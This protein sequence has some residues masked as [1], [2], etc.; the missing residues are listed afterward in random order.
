L[1][2][3][4]ETNNLNL[5]NPKRKPAKRLDK[6]PANIWE[7]VLGRIETKVSPHSYRTWFRPT[8]F[9]AEDASSISVQV[10]NTWFAEWLETNYSVLIQETL[11]EM[12]HQG[13]VIDFKPLSES[14]TDPRPSAATA[15]RP[16]NRAT[17]NPKYTFETFVVSSCNQFAHAAA[18]A[19]AEQPTRAYNPLYIYGGVGLGK[20]HL[21]Q[22]IGNHIVALGN[23]R[24]HYISSEFFMNEL[25]NAIRFEKTLEFKERYRNVD[26]LLIDDIQ[27]LA[28]K[29]RT[30][31]EFFHTFN[32]LYDSQK[33]IVITSDV[34]PRDIPTLEERLR[35]RFEWGL[36]ADMQ[37]PDLETKVA[38]LQKK[39]ES[40]RS[41]VPDEVSLF[42]A[43]NC[44]TNVRELEGAFNKVVAYSSMSG[45]EINLDMAKKMLHDFMACASPSAT[46]DSIMKLVSNYYNLPVRELKSKNNSRQVAFPRHVAMYLSKKLTNCSFPEIGRR[47]GGKHH[48]TV[49]HAVQK[50]EKK[51][52]LEDDFH[53]LLESFVRSLK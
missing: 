16:V 1:S 17:L 47:F 36:I 39:A 33:Q 27:F 7:E 29:E 44:G 13:L 11:R 31:E 24:I 25:I 10:P 34:P 9:V 14:R 23:R 38:I 30:Q 42:I 53:K 6:K 21:M 51:R 2:S 3:H 32:A 18:M 45:R 37:P 20:T 49:I 35:S 19:V 40:T 43:S 48:S 22:A 41:N 50:I 4:P 8:E 5:G 28:G 52:T 15:T 46:V 26:V 12:Q